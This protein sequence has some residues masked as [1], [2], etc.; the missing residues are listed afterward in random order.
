M[1]G[2]L[3]VHCN[4]R[5]GRGGGPALQSWLAE[6]MFSPS[7]C[8]EAQTIIADWPGYAPT[9]LRSLPGL[10]ADAGVG[11]ILYKDEAD[12]FGLG[13]FKALGGAFAVYRLLADA[14]EQRTGARPTAAMLAAGAHAEIARG[15]TVASATAGNHGRSVAWG[16]R[17]FGCRSVIF[18]GEGVGPARVA[19]IAAL[20]ATV[21]RVPGDYDASVRAAA[22]AAEANGWTVVSDTSYAGYSDIPRQVMLGYTVLLAELLDALPAEQVP[23][24]AIVP[25]GVGGLAAAAAAYLALRL[26]ERRP[27][28]TVVEPALADCLYQSAR[29]GRPVRASGALGSVMLGL[30]CGAVS[31]VAFEVLHR[32]ADAFVLISDQAAIAS[33]RRLNA[34]AGIVA[35]ECAGAGLAVLDGLRDDPRARAALGLDSASRVLL[36]GTEGATDPEAYR[37]LLGAAGAS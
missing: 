31:L 20:G 13:S 12:R 26:G 1:T 25:A 29:A 22:A 15:I 23:T 3:A 30:D 11:E 18:V 4:P 17:M 35:G 34:Q 7:E 19:A 21:E 36:I 33:M 14:I 2:A 16:A 8:A 32:L 10:A 28:F 27:H 24:H 5:T 37:R 9:P 6:T